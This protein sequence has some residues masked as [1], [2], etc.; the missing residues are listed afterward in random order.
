MVP[1]EPIQVVG[2]PR[3]V[4]LKRL[5]GRHLNYLKK[6]NGRWNV[7][8]ILQKGTDLT[9][10]EIKF[11][12]PKST[13]FLVELLLKDIKLWKPVEDWEQVKREIH[14]HLSEDEGAEQPE[15]ALVAFLCKE[16][17]MNPLQVYEMLDKIPVTLIMRIIRASRFTDAYHEMRRADTSENAKSY[18]GPYAGDIELIIRERLDANQT[19]MG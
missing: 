19:A 18:E 5:E 8:Y 7:K 14:A 6:R 11:L 15:E 12:P 16:Y 2:L 13:D 10:E 4:Q 3:L 9:K 17:T 1:H